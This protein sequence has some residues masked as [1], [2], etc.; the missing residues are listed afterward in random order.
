MWNGKHRAFVLRRGPMTVNQ[1]R[2]F[3]A[4]FHV[5]PERTQGLTASPS[6]CV[7]ACLEFLGSMSALGAAISVVVAQHISSQ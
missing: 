3:Q 7:Q 2:F 4:T 6:M 5:G 1:L